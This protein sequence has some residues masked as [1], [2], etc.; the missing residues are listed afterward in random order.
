MTSPAAAAYPRDREA[1]IV[2]RDGSTVHVRPVREGD[3]PGMRQFLS[4]VSPEST[5]F[6]FFGIPDLNWVLRWSLDVDYADRFAVVAE[7]GDP[8]QIVAHAAYVREG[9]EAAEVAFL[10]AD[11]WQ[12]QGISTVLLAHIAEVAQR[13]GIT[14]FTAE[15]LPANHRMIEV[16]RES[17]FPVELRSSP[18]E[19]HVEM[20]TSLSADALAR[21]EE[22]DR[23]AA[24]AAVRSFLEPRAVAVIGASRRR[25][26]V[27][28]EILHNL[29]SAGFAGTVY[30]VNRQAD[31][32]QSLPAY[33]SVGDIP[34]HVD[35]AVVAVPAEE[36]AEVAREC[37]AAGVRALLVISA[38]FAEVGEGGAQR[39]RELVEIC[40]SCGMRLV[41]PNCLGIL[42]TAPSVSLNA[43]FAPHQA[44]PGRIGFMSQSGGLGIAIVEAASRLGIG[45]SAFVSVGNK[46]DLSGNDFLDYWEQDP[47]T[48]VALMYLESFGNPRKF[49]R[50]AP[51]FARKK[52][53]LVVKSGRSAAGARATSSHTGALL[54]ASDVTVGALFEQ[55]GVIRTDTLHELFAV[56]ALL[57][58]QP[59]PAGDR[60]AIVTNAGGPGIL[61]AD[62]CQADGVDVPVLPA[63]VQERLAEFLPASASVTNPVDMI[64]TATAEH[65]RRVLKTL[66]ESEACDAI[67]AIF[68][69]PLVTEAA[70][71]AR[72]IREVA[73]TQARVPIAAVFMSAEGPPSELASSQVRVPGYEFPEEAAR[74]VALAAKHGRWR[75]KPEGRRIV[76]VHT[77]PE[78]AA[79]I[80][81][82][83]LA[84]G[85]GWLGPTEVAGLLEAH[86]LPVVPTVIVPD[87]KAAA[88][89]SAEVGLPVALKA[90]GPGLIHKSDV[91]GVRLGLKTPKAVRAAATEITASVA[92]AREKL[93]GFIVQ[94]MVPA[95]VELIVGVVHDPSFGPVV[96]CGAGGTTAELVKDVVVRLAPLTDVD[97]SEMI[98]GL[99]SF[100]LLQGYRGA[101]GVD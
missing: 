71:V 83:A 89:R 100:P 76:P 50:I 81:S 8:R 35:L 82:Q 74:A 47:N 23:I 40:R 49:G 5:A 95:G 17:G 91:G 96:A 11:A 48:E 64:A 86:G 19:I 1:E 37:G 27:G 101:P 31:S 44:A 62:A 26:T 99:R 16:F 25:G 58:A 9:P 24:V 13:H 98:R 32:V 4:S 22:R 20:P 46:A 65:Y 51:R 2:L 69:P 87:A 72:A 28:G 80:I 88:A 57:S 77:H 90:T 34:T 7:S 14:T 30:A 55:A 75:S 38:G 79:A 85:A 67:L 59:V 78:R 45:L 18:D 93:S 41:G 73:E 66:I 70:D 33:H 15:V 52:P 29:V 63:E 84:Q 21:F 60:V 39:Q 54:S 6:R 42:N 61:C 94:P 92:A 43:T 56:G 36:V 68:V 10:V 53:L 3:D 97:A 12:G